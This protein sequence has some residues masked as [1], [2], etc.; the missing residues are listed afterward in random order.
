MSAPI[1]SPSMSDRETIYA[2]LR[3]LSTVVGC[4][5]DLMSKGAMDDDDLFAVYVMLSEIGREVY[6][7]WKEARH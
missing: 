4:M 5:G 2:K 3:F 6:P 1:E 7:E